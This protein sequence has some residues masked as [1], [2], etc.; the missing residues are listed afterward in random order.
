MGVG[1]F[2]IV[3]QD[4]GGNRMGNGHVVGGGNSTAGAQERGE[5]PLGK[6]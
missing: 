4:Q 6:R 2:S 1:V 3:E 5:N